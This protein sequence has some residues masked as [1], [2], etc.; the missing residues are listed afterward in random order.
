MTY[1][2]EN[3]VAV[4][5]AL[6]EENSIG[7]II[8]STQK[9]VNH[10]IVLNDGSSDRTGEI[11]SKLKIN[12]INN[13][14]KK[15]KGNAL[16]SL[17]K[18]AVKYDPDI[19]VSLDADGQHD[20][21]EIPKLIK[22]II[23]NGMDMVIGSR[24]LKGSITDISLLRSIGLNFINFLH[25]FLFSSQI[26]DT[27]SGFRSFSKRA[28]NIVLQSKEN[29]YGIESEQLIIALNEGYKILEVPVNIKYNGLHKTSKMNFIKH[30]F[31]IILL[32]LK[33]FVE[34]I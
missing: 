25:Y 12:L 24:F 15:G 34:K 22:P 16:R 6:N 1:I 30:G 26:K 20:P 32:L 3:I 19:I 2:H 8:L 4:I 9:Y 11:V 27:Q 31:L 21:S 5:P 33:L 7:D 17:F 14:Y 18:E 23:F 10:I 13:P 28:F 29:G